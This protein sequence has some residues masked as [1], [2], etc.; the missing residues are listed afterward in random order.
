MYLTTT[1]IGS[2]EQVNGRIDSHLSKITDV[3]AFF[4]NLLH[5]SDDIEQADY[6]LD[7]REDDGQ[8]LNSALLS[9]FNYQ[10][11]LNKLQ[12]EAKNNE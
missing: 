4:D 11:I 9:K 10:N 12:S 7:L 6:V 3:S 8:V 5:F 2:K 1:F